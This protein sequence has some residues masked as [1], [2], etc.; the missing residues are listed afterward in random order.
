LR[1][2]DAAAGISRLPPARVAQGPAQSAPADPCLDQ[3]LLEWYGNENGDGIVIISHAG[4]VAH[5]NHRFR[6]LW[7]VDPAAR[8]NVEADVWNAVLRLVDEPQSVLETVTAIGLDAAASAK[9]TWRLTNGQAIECRTAP[10]T[11]EGGARE[12][13]IWSFH[14][15][16]TNAPLEDHVLHAQRLEIIGTVACQLTHE[17]R[18]ALAPILSAVELAQHALPPDHRANNHLSQIA[19]AAGQVGDLVQKVLSFGRRG[20]EP[21]QH[22]DL[23]AIV[24]ESIDLLSAALP[25]SVSIRT[26]LEPVPAIL[27]DAREIQQVLMNLCINAWHAIEPGTGSI[28]IEVVEDRVAPLDVDDANALSPGRYVRLS[29]SDDGRGMD[30][31]TIKQ[32]FLP[33]YTTKPAHNG[34][35]LGLAVVRTIAESHGAR[36]SVESAVG[37]GTTFHL[38]FRPAGE[39]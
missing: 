19:R 35:G 36:I 2:G 11:Q 37:R 16:A 23:G 21:P 13:R 38:R 25:R 14:D 6:Q 9:W 34:T 20:M 24:R 7:Q 18:N 5:A 1:A 12:S 10:L 29:I 27:A 22:H 3:L 8:L 28:T 33:F 15:I 39:P 30:E 17:I 32:I 4:T 26:R 31:Q